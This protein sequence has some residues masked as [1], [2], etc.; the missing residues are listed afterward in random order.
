MDEVKFRWKLAGKFINN[1]YFIIN[2][3]YGEKI[4]A[5][6]VEFSEY[7]LGALPK[8]TTFKGSELVT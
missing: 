3:S 5:V 4:C 6:I 7:Q 1:T 2:K 8:F